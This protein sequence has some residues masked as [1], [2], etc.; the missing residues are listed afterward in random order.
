M[1]ATRNRSAWAFAALLA[2]ASLSAGPA[3]GMGAVRTEE[4]EKMLSAFIMALN[5]HMPPRSDPQA[6]AGL[7][8]EDAVQTQPFG[9]PPGM[10]QRGRRALADF[11]AGLGREW[12]TWVL[13]ESSRTVQGGKAVWEGVVQGTRKESGEEVRM[14]VVFALM[15]GRDGKVMSSR[16]YLDPEAIARAIR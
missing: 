9:D 15:F 16:V 10:Q 8:A 2:A 6:L 13:V 12:S 7:F 1:K 11:F 14:P 5:A 3:W 4:A